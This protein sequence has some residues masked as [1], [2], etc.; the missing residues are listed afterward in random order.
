[1]KNVIPFNYNGAEIRT[2]QDE[3]GKPWFIA[4]DIATALGYEYPANAVSA[5]C[6]YA[7]ILKVGDLPTLDIPSRGLSIIPESDVYRLIMRSKLDS[8]EQFQDWVTEEVL[9]S[10][11]KTGGYIAARPEDTD[12][13]I[14]ARAVLVANEAMKRKDERIKTLEA[15]NAE[16][17]PKALFADAVSTAAT[18]ILVGELA[19]IIKQN[20][21]DMGQ[22]RLFSFLRDN[23]YLIK[24][25]GTDYNMPTQ[26]SMER[27]WFEIKER[28]IVNPDDSTRITKTSKI[29]GKGQQY[30]INLFLNDPDLVAA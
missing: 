29:T 15:S 24:R 17:A 22:N 14:M 4:R 13:E 3:N 19:K 30:F 9:P 5:H 26:Y 12:E 16:M 20:G 10:I 18:S 25:K 8:A 7:E 11:R 23:G 2:I 28:T 6:K 21:V 1:M 27:G